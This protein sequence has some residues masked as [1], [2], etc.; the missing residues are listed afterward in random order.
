MGPLYG[1]FQVKSMNFLCALMPTINN[2][3]NMFQSLNTPREHIQ[4]NHCTRRAQRVSSFRG[5]EFLLRC[6]SHSGGAS[7]GDQSESCY[8]RLDT[9]TPT[10]GEGKK[11]SRSQ[12]GVS[13][14]QRNTSAP[15]FFVCLMI[16]SVFVL[17]Q[18]NTL[19]WDQRSRTVWNGK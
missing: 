10:A 12:R 16:I 6:T 5:E 11:N 19:Q 9:H 3:L 18:C 4:T 2:W 15:L 13:E 1:H 14:E 7:A 8:I 17:L